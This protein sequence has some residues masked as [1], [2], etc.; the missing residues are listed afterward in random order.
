MLGGTYV[1]FKVTYTIGLSLSRDKQIVPNGRQRGSSELGIYFCVGEGGAATTQGLPSLKTWGPAFT[2]RA[3]QVGVDPHPMFSQKFGF[4]VGCLQDSRR[5]QFL[6]DGHTAKDI[7]VNALCK[8]FG[9]QTKHCF[10]PVPSC[11]KSP[12]SPS[13]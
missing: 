4:L 8:D 10:P 2:E 1:Y 7:P 13:R 9:P 12:S 3:N 5:L 6:G 11:C